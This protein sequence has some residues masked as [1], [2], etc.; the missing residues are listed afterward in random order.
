MTTGQTILIA[1]IVFVVLSGAILGV[2]AAAWTLARRS[3][4]R[5]LAE[6]AKVRHESVT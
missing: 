1:V 4:N 3:A 5:E 6:R 2:F